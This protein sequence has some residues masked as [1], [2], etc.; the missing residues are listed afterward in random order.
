MDLGQHAGFILAAY[1]AA[2][3]VIGL[4]ALW[5]ILDHRI[6]RRALVALE[7]QGIVR[8]AAHSERD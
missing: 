2:A 8:R 1:G 4:V 7:E 3:I 5:V 6:Q